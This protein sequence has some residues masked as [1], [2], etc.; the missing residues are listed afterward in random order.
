MSPNK[1]PNERKV[2]ELR[3]M[4]HN[5]AA[6]DLAMLFEADAERAKK[7]QEGAKRK[8]GPPRHPVDQR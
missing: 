7:Q 4:G 3:A 6:D 5:E 2:E 8:A 1:D